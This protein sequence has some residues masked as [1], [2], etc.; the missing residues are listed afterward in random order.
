MKQLL[1]FYFFAKNTQLSVFPPI[2]SLFYSEK[3]MTINLPLYF[4]TFLF[5]LFKNAQLDKFAIQ[6]M[7]NKTIVS[8]FPTVSF[9]FYP[10]P[11]QE[12]YDEIDLLTQT[13]T[14]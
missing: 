9:L 2:L 5:V 8:L 7:A 13:N 12:I 6:T 11:F 14:D 3:R 1:T 4:I 10:F